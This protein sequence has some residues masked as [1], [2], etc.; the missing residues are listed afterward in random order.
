MYNNYCETRNLIGQYPCRIRQSCAEKP[1][2]ESMTPFSS[3]PFFSVKDT[4]NGHDQLRLNQAVQVAS[5]E[6]LSKI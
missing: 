2:E 1:T 6:L 5:V 3:T 4:E